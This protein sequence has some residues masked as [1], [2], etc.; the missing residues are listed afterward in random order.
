[1]C[2]QAALVGSARGTGGIFG[3]GGNR[4][5]KGRIQKFDKKT[6]NYQ[7]GLAM[8][9]SLSKLLDGLGIGADRLTEA[10]RGN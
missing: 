3:R 6:I 5:E 8:A 10:S 1:M 4:Y 2:R 9:D 7:G